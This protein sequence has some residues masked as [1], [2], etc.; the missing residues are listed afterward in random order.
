M[1]LPKNFFSSRIFIL[2]L[3]GLAVIGI[4]V[5]VLLF[6]IFRNNLDLSSSD[7][8]GW[9]QAKATY[10]AQRVLLDPTP[11]QIQTLT[12]SGSAVNAVNI[13]FATTSPQEEQAYQTGLSALQQKLG[14]TTHTDTDGEVDAAAAADLDGDDDDDSVPV[15]Q[16]G[17]TKKGDTD[18][19]T[20]APTK[21][22]V[23]AGDN[24]ESGMAAVNTIYAY[25]LIHDPNDAQRKLYYLWENTF[26]VDSQIDPGDAADKI[27]SED[28]DSLDK[29][30]YDNAYGNYIDMVGK[31]QT[32][33]A[34]AKYLDLINSSQTD[35]NENYSREFM[36]L[37]LMGEYTPLDTG[38]TTPNYT[39]T[40]VNDLAY[41]LTGYKSSLVNGLNT[42]TFSAKAHYTGQKMFLGTNISFTDPEQAIPYIV[43]QRRTQVSEFLANKIL[44]FY[45]SD[46]PESQDI[47]TF[48]GILSQNNFEILPSLK[49]LFT[50]DIMYR[51]QYMQ[52]ERYKSPVE[53]VASFYTSLY[54]RNDYSI[55]PNA[56]V[57]TDLGY[58]PMRPG[59][60]F[61]RPGYDANILF[62]SGSIL[63]KWIGDSDRILR[64]HT[65][66]V[67]VAQQLATIITQ[68][69]ITTPLA[70]VQYFEN[71][72]YLG[73]K[74]PPKAESDITA[75]VTSSSTIPAA[76]A[77]D[78]NNAASM[79]KMIG[80]LD[81]LYAQPEFIMTG[82]TPSA[83]ALPQPLTPS[84][85]NASTTLV[86]IRLHGGFDYQQLVANI[87]DPDYASNRQSLDLT[88][89]SIPLGAGYVLN[90]AA[91]SLMQFIQS[92]QGFLVLAVGLPGQVRAHDIASQ[93][94]ETGL[95]PGGLGIGAALK[96]ADPSLNLVSLTNSPPIFYA[97]VSS[98]QMGTSNLLLYPELGKDNESTTGQ[99][100]MLAQILHDR[101]LPKETAAYYSQVLFLNQLANED[102]A[103]G[104]LGTPGPTNATQFPFLET[105]INKGIGNVYYLY[106]DNTYDFHSDEDP[107]FDEQIQL[108]TQQVADFYNTE[109]KKTNLTIVFFS[110]FGRTDKINGNDGTD[111]G[112]G[113]GMTVLSNQLHWP[114]VVGS[115]NPSTDTNNWT[116][117]VVDERDVW[118]TI[119]NSL[120]GVPVNTLFGRTQTIASYPVTIP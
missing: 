9:D 47:V 87:K 69:K 83:I 65:D 62:Y 8:G 57:L 116:N 25:Q 36:Q 97:G 30:L 80:M 58:E 55:I 76:E 4:G 89:T 108:L 113:G 21:T 103:I 119:F 17:K 105:L 106:A 50:S 96:K 71:R 95:N 93:Q 66:S 54:G 114:T 35:P 101:E 84:P 118:D 48:A 99:L 20:D 64:A 51:P 75:F 18:T 81:L 2:S 117:V 98:I 45:V 59:S 12:Q 61:G 23:T 85:Q 40:D 15:V 53:L 88:D 56:T 37:F 92:K 16:T 78:T 7:E 42:V 94:M 120:Y 34:M 31:V 46:A 19:D 90:S 100:Q 26:S 27:S 112:T 44:K 115:L 73:A 22:D 29:I 70:L 49:W 24:D 63:D 111:H 43:S 14:Q 79:N 110:E 74:L 13:L 10:L 3:I 109:S 32:T 11:A 107:K 82:G 72:L 28:V 91:K 77:L 67:S 38:M 52:E 39:D 1:H 86:I 33:Y 60:I 102:I 5:V 68:N 41:L 104:G 6:F